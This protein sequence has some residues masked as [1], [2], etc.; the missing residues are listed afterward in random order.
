MSKTKVQFVKGSKGP[1]LILEGYSYFRNNCNSERTYWL[2]SQNR[3]RKCKARLITTNHTRTIIVKNQNHNHDRDLQL[4][5]K[6]PPI[7]YPVWE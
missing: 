4:G 5:T 3:Y 6:E 2:C 1:K 7:P